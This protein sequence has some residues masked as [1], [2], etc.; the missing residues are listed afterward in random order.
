MEEEFL[1]NTKTAFNKASADYDAH[2]N[3]NIILKWMRGIVQ[4]VY[5]KYLKEGEDVLELNS[6]T[7]IDAVFLA[8]RGINVYATDISNEMV[9]IIKVKYQPR[10]FPSVRSVK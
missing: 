6:G 9:A 8:Q 10:L 5:L 4:S 3:H 2:E 1:Q 7:G